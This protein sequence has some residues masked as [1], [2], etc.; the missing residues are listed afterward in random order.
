LSTN[1]EKGTTVNSEP[2]W[3]N[4]HEQEV[5]RAFRELLWGFESAMDRQLLRDSDLSG[6]EYSVLA[7]LSEADQGVLRARDI[8]QRLDWERS[9]LSHLLKRMEAR[10]LVERVACPTDARGFNVS[11]TAAGWDVLRQAAPG[12]VTFVRENVFDPLS[13]A[14]REA[15]FSA[16][17]KIQQSI[18]D[19][20]LW[21]NTG[22][23]S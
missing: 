21:G 19:A 6:V 22:K 20:G 17:A 23:S 8:A 11:M 9:R 3:L 18:R 12:H 4:D 5:W 7:S 16:T 1:G 2:R 10:G 15:L 14:E 13:A